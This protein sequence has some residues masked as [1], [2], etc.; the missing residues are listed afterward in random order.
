[1]AWVFVGSFIHLE[2]FML[3]LRQNRR[4]GFTLIELLVVIAIIAILIALLVPAVQKVRESAARTQ[5][6]N[7]LKQ[8]V[9][10]FHTLHDVR[11]AL[12]PAMIENWVDPNA[13]H[14]Y[15]GPFL[16][17]T[18]TGLFFLLPFI[19]QDPLYK[20]AGNSVY[21]NNVHTNQ[22]SV[23]QGPL[24]PTSTEKTHGWGVTSYAMNYQVFG[25]PAHPWGWAWGCMGSS[26][27]QTIQDG[28]SNTVLMAEK[29]AACQGGISG[30][31]GN[32]WAHGWWNADWMPIFANSD[33]HGG[34]AWLIPQENPTNATCVP[35]R[36]TAFSA[37]VCMVGMADGQVRTVSTSIA[38]L[39]W[40][41]SLTPNDGQS[42]TL[43]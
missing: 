10:G 17:Q 9:L 18:G 7:N 23:F 36:A 4:R 11:K 29:R 41:Y 22:I 25:R 15:G 34:N 24:D 5:S 14:M 1:V 12:P 33:V 26:R 21:N 31:N 3:S 32:L 6:A 8:I 40:Q 35:Y 39:Q 42:G 19:E 38:Q 13:G 2:E 16:K 43:N 30:S 28:T 37:G 20:L 27:L